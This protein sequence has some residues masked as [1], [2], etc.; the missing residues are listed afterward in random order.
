[1]K[2]KQFLNRPAMIGDPCCH[3][4][5]YLLGM[6]QTRM[7]RTKVIDRPNQE[8][9][10][11]Q[12]PGLTG[13]SPATTSQWRETFTESR[14]ES[15]EVSGVDHPV[16]LRAT[17]ERLD[18]C[19]RAIDNAAF[20]FDD[21]P[22]LVALDDLGDQDVSPGPQPWT[23]AFAG[24]RRITEGLTNCPALGTQ[25]IRTKQDRAVQSAGSH[26]FNKLPDERHVTVLVDFATEPQSGLDHQCHRHPHDGALFLDPNF[27]GLNVPQVTRLLDQR[28]VHGLTPTAGSRP[29]IGDGAFIEAKSRHHRLDRAAMGEQGHHHHDGLRRCVQA[30][31]HRAFGGA[32]SFVALFADKALLLLRVETKVAP[33]NLASS[34]AIEIGT[35]YGCG[36]HDIAP[37]F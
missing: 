9:P 15:L 27:I 31:E 18:T 37:E 20:G 19:G 10:L 28:F 24:R 34:V 8:H 17:S 5:R 33:A 1:M 30:I 3:R 6:S 32:K 35:E 21:T 2:R 29:A 26:S 12:S 16:T 25:A 23:T 4:W 36:I 14:M 13:Q 7:R 11:V 22:L